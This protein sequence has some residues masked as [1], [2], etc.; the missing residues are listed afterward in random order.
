VYEGKFPVET[1]DFSSYFAAAEAAGVE[2]MFPLIAVGGSV[3]FVKE[4]SARQSPMVV[5]GILGGGVPGPGGWEITDGKCEYIAAGAGPIS[6]GYPYTSKTLPVR[7]AYINR[8][9]EIPSQNAGIA[10]DVLRYILSDAIER[11]GTLEVNS[12]IEAL[13]ETSIETTNAKNF[14]F[15]S[16][17]DAL[18]GENVNDPEADYMATI[19]F[20]WVDGEQVPIYPKKI[21]EEAGV[22]YTFPD[23]TGSW[24]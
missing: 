18:M 1:V 2:V 8:W 22:T 16:S 17:H 23:W 7:E 19:I 12:V 21:M 10:Y 14:V 4:Y 13:E 20:Q 5:Y 11:A 6:A 24:D 15:T 3:P 9:D